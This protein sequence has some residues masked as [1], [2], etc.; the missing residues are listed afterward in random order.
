PIQNPK[1]KI[2]NGERLYKTGDRAR[3]L[4]TGTI[5][6]LGRID[7]QVKLRGFRIELGEIEAVLSRYP[8]VRDVVVVA[9]EQAPGTRRLVAYIVTSDKSQVTS[10]ETHSANGD[11]D[12]S[13]VTRYSLL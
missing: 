5:A 2:Q 8:G 13:L 7:Q 3:W 12:S 10:N 9:R 1:S 4:P 11:C 6:F